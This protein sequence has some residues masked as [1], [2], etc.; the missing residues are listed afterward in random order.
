MA[1]GNFEPSQSISTADA[2]SWVAGRKRTRRP[3]ARGFSRFR[4]RPLPDSAARYMVVTLMSRLS[5]GLLIVVLVGVTLL[6]AWPVILIGAMLLL[7]SKGTD[8]W[9]RPRTSPA[10]GPTSDLVLRREVAG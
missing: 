4:P 7:L 8:A 3:N 9:K 2:T 1:K 6:V 5:I 10:H